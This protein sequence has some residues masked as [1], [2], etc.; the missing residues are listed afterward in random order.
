MA[1]RIIITALC[2]AGVLFMLAFLEG[3]KLEG[4]KADGRGFPPR[5]T[6]TSRAAFLFSATRSFLLGLAAIVAVV[7]LSSSTLLGQDTAHGGASDLDLLVRQKQYLE[8]ERRLKTTQNLSPSDRAFFRGILLNRKNQVARSIRALEPLTQSLLQGP[9]DRAQ[10]GLCSLADDYANSFR[11]AEAADTYAL[12]SRLPGYNEDESGCHAAL[13]AERWGL[14]R[15]APPQTIRL[16]GP[17]TLTENRTSA[18]FL[19]VDV[20]APEFTDQWILDTGANLSAVTRSVA[21]QL[22][23]KLSTA[24]TTSQGSNGIFVRIHTSVIPELQLGGAT[25]HNVPVL[26]F[27]DKDLSFPQLPYQIHGS[28]GFPVLAALGRI[29]FTP[30]AGLA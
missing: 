14:L 24:E 13:E 2:G 3:L 26:V 9:T 8:L 23:L 25:L 1:T 6:R 18:G 4:L 11:Y 12:W 7:E 5:R 19:A 28:I 17:F 21:E 16:N 10:A 15:E 30:T 27:E 20:Q 22:G 29:S